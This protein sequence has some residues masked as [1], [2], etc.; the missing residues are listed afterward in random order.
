MNSTK[1]LTC[2]ARKMSCEGRLHTEL[3]GVAWWEGLPSVHEALGLAPVL[4]ERERE[5]REGLACGSREHT[6]LW[7]QSPDLHALGVVVL[8]LI[9]ALRSYRLEDQE[10][11]YLELHNEFYRS[12]WAT[13]EPV[14]N[15]FKLLSGWTH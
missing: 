6:E 11:S 9:P 8:A 12:A 3:W 14:S 7:V 10:F 13:H 1:S 2:C 4:R 5:R 15:N